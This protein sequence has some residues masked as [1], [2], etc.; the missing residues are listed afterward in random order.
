MKTIKYLCLFLCIAPFIASAQL[1]E[2]Y[3]QFNIDVT[4][5]DTSKSARQSAS[6]MRDSKMEIYFAKDLSRV[7]FKLG[8]LSNTS[9]RINRKTNQGISISKSVY[10]NFA[11]QGTANEISGDK[12]NTAVDGV[13]I[14]PFDEY[15]TI[16]G[17][18]CRKYVMENNGSYATYWITEEISIKDMG[19]QI[20]NASLPGFPLE[21]TSIS[22][23][24]RMSFKA[25]N[26]KESIVNKSDVFSTEVP[27][28]F[29]EMQ[30]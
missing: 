8:T 18:K 19:Q 10:G 24:V 13:K 30:R 4:A 28:G 3:F 21:F 23:G 26:Y 16:L 7:D 17:F 12:T 1:E 6:M 11:N 14:T 27:A 5:V 2:G 25:S 20:V 29:T 22:E 15:K 9:I